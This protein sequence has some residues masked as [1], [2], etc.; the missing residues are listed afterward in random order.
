MKYLC[1]TCV[2]TL[3]EGRP[4][5]EAFIVETR[6]VK[7]RWEDAPRW[8]FVVDFELSPNAHKAK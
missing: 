8:V 5:A 6:G 2:E 1:L 7:R 3:I 4:K